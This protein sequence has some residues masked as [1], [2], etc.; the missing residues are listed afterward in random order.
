MADQNDTNENIQ[1]LNDDQASAV[2]NAGT[3]D[4]VAGGTIGGD[5]ATGDETA[6]P[7]DDDASTAGDDDASTSDADALTGAGEDAETQAS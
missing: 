3:E 1:P 6:L 4:Q 7:G 5:D 2:E